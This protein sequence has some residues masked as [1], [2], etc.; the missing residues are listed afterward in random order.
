MTGFAPIND[1]TCTTSF[2]LHRAFA[3]KPLQDRQP[4]AGTGAQPYNWEQGAMGER[5][6]AEARAATAA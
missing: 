2:Y 3:F 1:Y 4:V 5:L 6:A